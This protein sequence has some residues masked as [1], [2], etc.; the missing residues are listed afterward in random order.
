MDLKYPNLAIS[1]PPTQI[2]KSRGYSYPPKRDGVGCLLSVLSLMKGCEKIY[3][4]LRKASLAP[5]RVPS[6]L[7][8]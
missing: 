4:R 6:H 1:V 5:K 7:T 2:H 8:C 3:P